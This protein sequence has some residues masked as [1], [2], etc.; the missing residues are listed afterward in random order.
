MEVVATQDRIFDAFGY[1]QSIDS[2]RHVVL[3]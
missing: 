1:Y 2:G 3:R